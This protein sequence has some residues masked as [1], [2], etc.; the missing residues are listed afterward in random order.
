MSEIN[1]Q[2]ASKIGSETHLSSFVLGALWFGAARRFQRCD[3]SFVLD[4]G[5]S[6]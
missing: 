5:F 1:L 6:R 4:G 3:K 2:G